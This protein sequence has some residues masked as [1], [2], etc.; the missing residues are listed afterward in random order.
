MD[1]NRIFRKVALERMS[2][3]EQLDQLLRVTTPRTWLALLSLVAFLTAVIAWGYWGELTT[4]VRGE[5]VLVHV[6][7]PTQTT[8]PL[9]SSAPGPDTLD[10][11][12][13]V[14]S[15]TAYEIRPGMDAEVLPVPSRREEH[16]FVRGT[17]LS[18]SEAPWTQAPPAAG[19]VHAPG[20][21]ER[22]APGPLT[23]VRIALLRDPSTASGYGWSSRSGASVRMASG[24][25]C[26]A[27]IVTRRQ[28]PITLVVPG[29]DARETR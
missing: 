14:P 7:R 29:I 25:R 27:E 5:G 20:A 9:P 6:G 24:T 22:A 11:V 13:Y 21:P 17:V 18:V 1:A 3:P 23:E 12:V 26:S 10:A 16:G 8:A 2:S 4:K 28:R 15:E 19:A